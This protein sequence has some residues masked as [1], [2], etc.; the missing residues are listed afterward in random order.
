MKG[1]GH[2]RKILCDIARYA[3]GAVNQVLRRDE[4]LAR[5]LRSK[6]TLSRQ[7]YR[8]EHITA[9]MAATL[10]ERFPN[11]VD[12][13]L[14]T[15]REEKQ[16]GADWYWRFER[17]DRA[18]HARV[19]AKR[20]QRSEFGQ[21]DH[22]GHIDIDLPQLTQ[23]LEA[24][25]Q[26]TNRLPGLHAWLATYARF[27]ATPPCGK[28]NLR[29]CSKHRHQGACENHEPSLWIANAAEIAVLNV[30]RASIDQIIH[31]SV[32]LDCMLPCIDTSAAD[33]GPPSKGF[34]LRDGL[35]RYGE[36]I[37]AIERDA[38]LRSYFE[39]ALRVAV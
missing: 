25:D 1:E 27:R 19:Q 21:P 30:R 35:P 12:I 2:N 18:I 32:R 20:V 14:F 31:K 39:G 16:T 11:H 36:C 17:G 24:T 10:L 9:E 26:A 8:E 34:E 4:L 33:E 13:V 22:S 3:F 5:D 28:R 6:T 29:H 7:V 37:E 38:L 15:P 23:L